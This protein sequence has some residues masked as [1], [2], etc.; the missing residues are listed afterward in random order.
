MPL[1]EH[2]FIARQD[3]SNAQAEGLIEHFGAVLSDNGGKLVDH[4]YWGVK[5]MAYKINKNRKGHYSFLRTDAP[6]EAVQEMERL[7]RLHDDVMRVLTIKV[8]EHAEGPSIQMQKRD[9]R[10]DRRGRRN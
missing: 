8:D 9:E 5:T 3:L 6:S 10:D 2:V 7:M 1:Y 4:E